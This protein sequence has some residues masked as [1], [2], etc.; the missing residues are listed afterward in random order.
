MEKDADRR[1]VGGNGSDD[2][3]ALS[4]LVLD[5]RLMGAQFDNRHA[6]KAVKSD[7]FLLLTPSV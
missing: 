7:D 1:R 3:L 4:L 6:G 5:E 2:D